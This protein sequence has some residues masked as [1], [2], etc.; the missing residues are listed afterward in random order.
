MRKLSVLLL[1]VFILVQTNLANSLLCAQTKKTAQPDTTKKSAKDRSSLELPDVIIYG[2]DTLVRKVGKKLDTAVDESKIIAPTL[3]YQPTIKSNLKSQKFYLQP[4]QAGAKSKKMLLFNYGRFQQVKTEAGWWQETDK[5]NFGVHGGYSRSDGQFENSQFANGG[6]N[7]QVGSYLSPDFI[8]KT[9]GSYQFLDYGLYG[10][11]IKKLTRKKQQS[12]INIDGQWL[13]NENSSTKVELFFRKNNFEDSDSTQESNEFGDSEFGLT[14]KYK[15]KFKAVRLSVTGFYYHNNFDNKDL[16]ISATQNYFQLKPDFTFAIKQ[17]F[18]FKAGLVF[19]DLEI[20]DFI[21]ETLFSPDIEII[22]TL[23]QNIGFDFKASRAY[24]P[25]NYCKWWDKN[26]FISNQFDLLPLKKKSELQFGVEYR[27]VSAITFKSDLLRQDWKN[28]AY[29]SR[30]SETGLFQL[31]R[32]NDVVLLT[33]NLLAEIDFSSKL[34]LETGV[35]MIFDSI[36]NDTL[37]VKDESLP[38]QEQI[39]IPVNLT[40][41]VSNTF[42]ASVNFNWVG[43]RKISLF[44]DDEL[45][46]C[47]LLSFELQKRL[48]NHYSIYLAGKNLL[49]QKNYLWQ[50]YP[51]MG[52]YFEAGIKGNW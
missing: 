5:L 36:K 25:I 15:T 34:K 10:A 43:A 31:N 12:E 11:E 16:N 37:S 35:R 23:S 4:S 44:D 21:S 48:F 20:I 42:M 2:K 7:A 14:A 13:V 38:Y 18:V 6:I 51:E 45:P 50:N 26:P 28:Y 40:Y 27:P 22:F 17:L 1:S 19:Q 32:L 49:D 39:F 30:N 47:G 29:W 24:A 3:D 9:K 8:V 52:I 46:S 41:Q 33:W